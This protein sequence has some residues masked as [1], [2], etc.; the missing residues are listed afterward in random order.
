MRY[1]CLILDHDDTAVDS[2]ASIHYPAHLEIMQELRPGYTPVSL[3]DW[4]RKNYS[5]GIFEYYTRE[6][7]FSPGELKTEHALWRQYTQ[8]RMPKFYDGF[9]DLL[10]QYRSVGGRITVVS[11][12]EC[13]IIAR[14]YQHHADKLQPEL[15]FGWDLDETKRKPHPYPVQA[16]L[17][18]LNIKPEEALIVD[19]LKPGAQ[20][21]KAAGVEVAAA[22]WGHSIPEIRKDMADSCDFYFSTIDEFA[23]FL[24][25]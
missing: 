15:I 23:D 14:H 11:H 22:G 3:D 12:S 24:L 21:G 16:I 1:K 2:T 13:D 18:Q 19:D 25:N 9:I 7:G 20:M 10:D 17:S 6:L 8:T 5:P 4:F